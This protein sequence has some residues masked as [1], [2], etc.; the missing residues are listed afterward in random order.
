[1]PLTGKTA[2]QHDI[3][4]NEVLLAREQSNVFLIRDVDEQ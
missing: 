4:Y 1:M 2:L 3:N